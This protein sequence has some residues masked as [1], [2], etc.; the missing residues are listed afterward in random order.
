MALQALGH[1]S[2]ARDILVD[3]DG[4]SHQQRQQFDRKDIV[5]IIE[6]TYLIMGQ[7]YLMLKQ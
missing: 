7:A 4:L 5:P 2:N 1:A 6:R 3:A